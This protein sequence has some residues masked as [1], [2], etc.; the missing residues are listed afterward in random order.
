MPVWRAAAVGLAVGLAAIWLVRS[1]E[2]SAVV[3]VGLLL[4]AAVGLVLLAALTGCLAGVARAFGARGRVADFVRALVAGEAVALGCLGPVQLVTAAVDST[5]AWLVHFGVLCWWLAFLW[6]ALRRGIGL[7]SWRAGGAVA[8]VVAA[9]TVFAMLPGTFLGAYRIPSGAS[10]PTIAVG[11]RIL[12]NLAAYRLR[13]PFLDLTLA[14]FGTPQ[15]GDLVVF[16]APRTG[17][18]FIKRVVAVAGDRIAVDDDG[19]LRLDGGAA[20]RCLLAMVTAPERDDPSSRR[21]EFDIFLERVGDTIYTV[22]QYHEGSGAPEPIRTAPGAYRGGGEVLVLGGE[23]PGR[24]YPRRGTREAAE[25]GVVVP[26]GELFVMGDN[27]DNSNDSRFWGTVPVESVVGKVWVILRGRP[28]EGADRWVWAH[29]P[30]D[31]SEHELDADGAACVG[32][33]MGP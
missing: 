3:L 19:T 17:E 14:E 31:T 8:A 21:A 11:D 28:R 13:V 29:D 15:R 26:P 33:L 6:G 23:L 10:L 2:L 25:G 7:P 12:V 1:R 30:P 27:R 9:A 32:R 24:P 18:D 20:P 4:G 5:V 16:T 22:R